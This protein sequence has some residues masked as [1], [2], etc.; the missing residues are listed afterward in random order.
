MNLDKILAQM[1][2]V[3]KNK[4][5]RAVRRKRYSSNALAISE[6]KYFD[7]K[8][9]AERKWTDGLSRKGK[10]TEMDEL[11]SDESGK[12]FFLASTS[13]NDHYITNMVNARTENGLSTVSVS[14]ELVVNKRDWNEYIRN[15]NTNRQVI[16][17]SDRYGM[18]IDGLNYVDYSAHGNTVDVTIAG[19][20]DFVKTEYKELVSTFDVAKCHIEWVYS[21]NGESVNIPMTDEKTPITEMYPFLKEETIEDYYNRFME[22]SASILLLIGPPGTGKT[23]F[24]RGLLNH[25]QKNAIVTYDEGILNKDYIFARFIEDDAAVMVIE[26]ADNFLKSRADGNSMMH[27]FLNVGDG[28]ISMK[29]KKMIFSTNLPSISDIDSALIRPGRCFDIVTFENYTPEQSKKLAETLNIEFTPEDGKKS[30]SLAEIF[31]KQNNASPKQVK[32]MGFY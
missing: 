25:V 7:M 8:D 22:S 19:D 13:L 3:S 24:I 9:E 18:V 26:D 6:R 15:K 29:N 27:R 17:F 12:E 5:K 32:K 30:Y 21:A 1:G 10:I 11:N 2:Y 4:V 20:P 28:L 16:Q 23:T 14:E 31:H